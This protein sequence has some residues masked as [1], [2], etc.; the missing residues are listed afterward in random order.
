MTIHNLAYQGIFPPQTREP[1]RVAAAGILDRRR[2]VLRQH[3]VPEGRVAILPISITTVSPSYAREIQQRAAGH[4][5][6]GPASPAQRKRSPA[7]STASTRMHGIRNRILTSNATTTRPVCAAKQDNKRALQLRMGLQ[8]GAEDCRCSDVVEPAHATRRAS[9]CSAD[10]ADALV[11]LPAQLAV[12]G[13]GDAALQRAFP[14]ARA[15]SPG[16]IAVQIGF[17]EGLSHQIEAGADIVRDALA[18]RTLRPEPDVQ[19]ALRHAAAR[20]RHRR[21][22]RFSGRLLPGDVEEHTASGFVFAPL[23]AATLLENCR[24]AI[25]RLWRQEGSGGN[26]RR[27]A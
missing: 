23:D 27:T 17:D 2:R 9:T 21:L 26:C 12:L 1:A 25:V 5:H 7:Y 3:V 13:S 4:G 19:P 18:L 16:K 10:I 8:R 20:A 15:T 14:G 11:E 22:A 6:A 24:R